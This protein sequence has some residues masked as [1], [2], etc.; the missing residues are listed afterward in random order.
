MLV[1][2]LDQDI[3]LLI[4]S[5]NS[6]NHLHTRI[7]AANLPEKR[8]TDIILLVILYPQETVQELEIESS[9]TK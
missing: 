6:S 9:N 3:K 1:G 5:P 8:T 2:I 4:Q 7:I